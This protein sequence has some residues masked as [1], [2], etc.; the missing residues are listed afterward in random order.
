MFTWIDR[1]AS[2]FCSSNNVAVGTKAPINTGRVQPIC[3][4]GIVEAPEQ[5]DAG[6]NNGLPASGCS[7]TCTLVMPK[8]AIT[9]VPTTGTAPL[10][11]IATVTGSV[12]QINSVSRGDSTSTFG[13]W[14]GTAVTGVWFSTPHTYMTS[15]TYTITASAVNPYSPNYTSM[16]SATVVVMGKS[17]P[18][19]ICGNGIVEAPEQCDLGASN[20]LPGSGCSLTCQYTIPTCNLSVAPTSG[21]APLPVTITLTGFGGVIGSI[22]WGEGPIAF[23]PWL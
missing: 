9:V 14:M 8:C 19:P 13:P 23:G 21:M 5:C 1:N 15:G 11:V 3:G 18:R 4:N 7:A 20:G 6:A 22:Y 17:T 10:N 16:C 12:G 2:A